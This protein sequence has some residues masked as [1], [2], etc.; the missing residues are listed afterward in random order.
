MRERE[1]IAVKFGER[2]SDEEQSVRERD[3]NNAT[4]IA[5]FF[6]KK[7]YSLFDV[8]IRCVQNILLVLFL[9]T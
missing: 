8:L 2:F 3:L 9:E 1:I 4:K 5:E 7:G 6:V